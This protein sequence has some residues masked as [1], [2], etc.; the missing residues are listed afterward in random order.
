MQSDFDLIFNNITDIIILCDLDYT[1]T[2]SNR[3]A[4]VILG[5]GDS[6]VGSKCYKLFQNLDA[7]CPNCPL[8]STIKSKIIM[9]LVYYD[10]RFHEYFEE[11][12]YP[13]EDDSGNLRNFILTR[14]NVT[15][16][17]EIEAKSA[18]SKKMSALG[19][20]SSGV[21]HDFNNILTVV[22]CRVQMMQQATDDKKMLENLK[23]VEKSAKEGAEKVRQIQDF[24][25]PNREKNVTTLNL[26]KL[27]KEVVDL[28][29]P[30]SDNIFNTKGVIIN[31]QHDIDKDIQVKGNPSDLKHCFTNIIFNAIDAMPDGGVIKI[32]AK[33]KGKNI[34]INFADT[35]IGMTD[36]ITNKIF[37]PFFTTKGEHGTGLGM[38]EVYGIVKRQNGWL[39]IK[40]KVGR[41]TTI[42]VHLPNPKIKK[43]D[44]K[45]NQE[46][47]SP[48]II[49]IH[50]DQAGLGKLKEYLK[51]Y[52]YNIDKSI[53]LS[54]SIETYKKKNFDIAFIDI[55]EDTSEGFSAA[56]KLKLINKDARIILI[57]NQ[58]F[59]TVRP[60]FSNNIDFIISKPLSKIKLKIAIDEVV[61]RFE[62]NN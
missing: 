56:E 13:I 38:S 57:S 37:D 6:I 3:A 22:L 5:Y 47:K 18:Q 35:G 43:A 27:F 40:S 61:A 33:S 25:S 1:I 21:A 48:K 23:K 29:Q 34:V 42:S 24:A 36:E 62:D 54:Q 20:I 31:M 10:N 11:R 55:G 19:K 52:G 32:N 59:E 30:K 16:D 46:G 17:K 58:V 26:K 49:A 39:T 7:P 53:L 60:Q 8:D 15:K 28:T 12:T 41:G 2:K 50:K 4:N 9:P 44:I 51:E 14:R 45:N